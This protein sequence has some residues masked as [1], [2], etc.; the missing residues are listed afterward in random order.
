LRRVAYPTDRIDFRGAVARAVASSG[1]ADDPLPL[2]T[3]HER[4]RPQFLHAMPAMTGTPT[5]HTAPEL[6]MAY[7]SLVRFLARD[8]L[9]HDVVFQDNPSLRF[10]FPLPM[11]DGFRAPDG[12][13][14][15]HHWDVL[16]GDPIEQINCWLPLTC[17]QGSNAMQ[18]APWDLSQRV[19]L[20]FA[21]DLGLD[22]KQ[23]GDSRMR[24]F[25]Y[26]C[27]DPALQDEVLSTCRPLEIDYGDVALFDARLLHGTEENVEPTTRISID[28][29][30]LS[31][32]AWEKQV[33]RFER[34]QLAH[35]YP[36]Q[37][38]LKGHFYDARTAF[39]L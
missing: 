29:R 11:T 15:S 32:D 20:R 10:H 9:G 12:R 6:Q 14:L 13:I 23:F 27:A 31:V 5:M 25:D 30:L 35:C 28:F 1:M 34:G 18:V 38:P 39:E 16:S 36:W 26:L 24:F 7:L 8:V 37:E 4:V 3:L 33:Q 22:L 2:E 19:I 21:D 17:C